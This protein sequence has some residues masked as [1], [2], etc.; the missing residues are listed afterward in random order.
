MTRAR[1]RVGV[2]LCAAAVFFAGCSRSGST[3][4]D[5]SETV[6]LPEGI[7]ACTDVFG[8][9]KVVD[10]KTFGEACSQ[11][12]QMVVPRP[13]ELHCA[14]QRVLYWN[15]FAWGYEGQE[16]TP[17]Q[18][19]TPD[20]EQSPPYDEAV[21]CLKDVPLDQQAALRNVQPVVDGGFDTFE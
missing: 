13:V 12:E 15:D 21:E 3:A 16:M 11:G 9:G 4:D 19:E 1:P 14:D 5:L 10:P 6:P 2:I 17:L 7:S 18:S 20:A 8:P